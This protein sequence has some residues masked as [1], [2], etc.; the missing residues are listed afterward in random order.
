MIEN[1]VIP[2]HYQGQA[3]RFNSDGWI[4]ATDVAR[5]FGKKPIKW[6][7]L[8]STKSYMAAL[9]RHLCHEVRKSD[10]KLVEAIRGRR[11]GT[12]LHPKLAVAF[13][14]WLDDDF[15]V[16]ADL[17]IDALLRGELNEKQQFDRACRALDDAQ[18]VASLSG[19][20]LARW[21]GRKP[22]LEYQVDY[23]REQLQMTLGLDAA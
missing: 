22:A 19:R 14:R 3:V 21:K 7:E 10:F 18:Q 15:A 11:A 12:W 1:N 5:R 13:A 9:E 6:L 2:F 17:H 16:W 23:W 20:E 8:P 4:N